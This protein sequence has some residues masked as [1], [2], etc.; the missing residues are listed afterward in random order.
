MTNR[1]V[2]L[3]LVLACIFV[4]TIASAKQ[5]GNNN[6]PVVHVRS[7][8]PEKS[9]TMSLNHE[10]EKT[11]HPGEEYQWTVEEK[12]IVYV[13]ALWGRLFASIHAFQPKRDE[14]RSAVYWLVKDSG[15]YL[16]WDNSTWVGKKL[17]ET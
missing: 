5:N 9:E 3:Y 6:L 15:F 2:S 8:L 7:A 10:V 12:K 16:S 1:G 11:L 4:S 17:W 14:G 13:E